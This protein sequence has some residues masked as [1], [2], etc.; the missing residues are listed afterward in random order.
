MT[1]HITG[2]TG[3]ARGDGWRAGP[4]VRLKDH[5]P[6]HRDTCRATYRPGLRSHDR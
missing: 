4:E 3:L 6:V 5:D 1:G 2:V